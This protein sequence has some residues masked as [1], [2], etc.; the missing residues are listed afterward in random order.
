MNTLLDV[1]PNSTSALKA[2]DNSSSQSYRLFM[3]SSGKT[4]SRVNEDFALLAITKM[5]NTG[6]ALP[7]ASSS[8]I[9]QKAINELKKLSGLTWDQLAKLFNVSRRSVHSWASGER[10]KTFNEENL[11]QVLSTIRYIDRGSA[12][13]N[14]SLLLQTSNDGRSF[15]DLLIVGDHKEIKRIL[16]FGNADK[17]P[18]LGALSAEERKMR[19][20]LSPNILANPLPDIGYQQTGK[21]RLARAV[22]SRRNSSGQ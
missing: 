16:G 4:T 11:N 2:L 15:F 19:M 22:R 17:Q 18:K 7:L 12:S 6:I 8:E 5:T 13:L 20:P 1:R 21:S 14:R 10:L 9:T 3:I